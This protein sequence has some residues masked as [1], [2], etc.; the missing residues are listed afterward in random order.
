M[1]WGANVTMNAN[2]NVEDGGA[3]IAVENKYA[4]NEDVVVPKCGAKIV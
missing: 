1:Y 4:F 3:L 2:V